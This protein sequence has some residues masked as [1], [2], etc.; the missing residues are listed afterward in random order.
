MA[1]AWREQIASIISETERNLGLNKTAVAAVPRMSGT[2]RQP[3]APV[4]GLALATP[5][6]PPVAPMPTPAPRPVMTAPS[7]A[8]SRPVEWQGQLQLDTA[9]FEAGRA[10]HAK[11]LE[12]VKFELDVRGSLV[13]KRLEAVRE[14]MDRN[15]TA[16][17]KKWTDIAEDMKTSMTAS[18][19][20]EGKLRSHTETQLGLL[21]N[22][23]EAAHL[24]TSRAVS[25][26]EQTA[27]E[28]TEVLRRLEADLGTFRQMTEVRYAEDSRKLATALEWQERV[29]TQLES[30]GTKGAE[31]GNTTA[32]E[33][34]D[35]PLTAS[36]EARLADMESALLRERDF[37]KSLELQLMELRDKGGPMSE[38]IGEAIEASVAHALDRSG[39]AATMSSLDEKVKECGRLIVRMGTELMEET[40]RRQMLEA[41][42]QELRMRLSG[43]EAVAR[44]PSGAAALVPTMPPTTTPLN[45]PWTGGGGSFAPDASLPHGM[46]PSAWHG[47]ESAAFAGGS[48]GEANAAAYVDELLGASTSA[49][50]GPRRPSAPFMVAADA[51]ATAPPTPGDR[52]DPPSSLSEAIDSRLRE[53]VPSIRAAALVAPAAEVANAPADGSSCASG[54]QFGL[55]AAP[56]RVTSALRVSRQELDARV[57]QI[58]G[59]HGHGTLSGSSYGQGE[60]GGS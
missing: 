48:G 57:Q 59:K 41:E 22:A 24:E 19:E 33:A 51:V 1:T 31:G 9:A 6:L 20:A 29:G 17:Q 32:A 23:S 13:E 18:I 27:I 42:V 21:R 16:T 49:G 40:K 38:A 55:P 14:E 36:H 34:A 60:S 44:S 46:A 37:R 3:L 50:A 7:T 47:D 35:G 56:Q 12:S 39:T 5:T 43:V 58:L 53:L 15:T 45:M 10:Q 54:T 11:V 28:N 25:A 26:L 4:P 30:K 8:P 2:V 52:A